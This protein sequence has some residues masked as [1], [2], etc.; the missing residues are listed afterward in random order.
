MRRISDFRQGRVLEA[1][2]L[3]KN[4]RTHYCGLLC[5][6]RAYRLLRNRATQDFENR[7][8]SRRRRLLVA[9]RT[10][11]IVRGLDAKNK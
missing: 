3:S 10:A 4:R 9:C 5:F 6:S 11:R 1:Y 7:A 8:L 2:F